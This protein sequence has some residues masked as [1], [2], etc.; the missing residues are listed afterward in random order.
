MSSGV[1]RRAG[2]PLRGCAPIEPL[3]RATEVSSSQAAELHEVWLNPAAQ[4]Y[5]D[6]LAECIQ[7]CD[8]VVCV[9]NVASDAELRALHD[10]GIGACNT[11]VQWS[12]DGKNRFSVSDPMAFEQDTVF[13]SAYSAPFEWIDESSVS[14]IN[15][16]RISRRLQSY[17]RP[18]L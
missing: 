11:Q 7:H 14:P 6:S 5:R 16:R 4:S 13:R 18:Q 9:P 1:S 17:L 12:A 2:A 8:V 15:V 3:V 10:A